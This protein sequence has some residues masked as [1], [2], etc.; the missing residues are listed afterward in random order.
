M[1]ALML[2]HLAQQSPIGTIRSDA[3]VHVLPVQSE[4][5]AF[6]ATSRRPAAN[7]LISRAFEAIARDA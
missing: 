3:D 4:A 2:R 5:T 6:E 1:Q 7:L